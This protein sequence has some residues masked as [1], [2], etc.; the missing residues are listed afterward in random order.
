MLAKFLFMLFNMSMKI[1][2]VN[3]YQTKQPNFQSCFRVYASK[4][5][6]NNKCF[7]TDLVRTSTNLFRED[8]DWFGLAKFIKTHFADKKK[9]NI[10]S[11]ACSDGSEAYTMAISLFENLPEE[12]H[13][14]FLPII[15]SDIDTKVLDLAKTRRINIEP[16]EFWSPERM[17]NCRLDKY[18]KNPR[19]TVMLDG[20]VISESDTMLSY[21]PIYKLAYA[22]KFHKA[23]ILS[24][25]NKLEDDGNSVVMCRNV[26]PYLSDAYTDEVVHAAKNKLKKGSLFITG[27]YDAYSKDLDVKLLNNDFC[28]SLKMKSRFLDCS[29]IFEHE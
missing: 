15:A 6:E 19:A 20:D 22:V 24:G 2:P 10:Y 1:M 14:K 9:V 29:N 5:L 18:F 11:M 7:R 27:D 26:F 4:S 28:Q 16:V 3:T 23:D 17:Y 25:L 12:L 8:L 21:Q 13:S